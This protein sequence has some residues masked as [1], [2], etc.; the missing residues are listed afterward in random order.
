MK[1]V[2]DSGL[3]V[4]YYGP[5]LDKRGAVMKNP[6][7]TYVKGEPVVNYAGEIDIRT[8]NTDPNHPNYKLGDY[9][10]NERSLIQYRYNAAGTAFGNIPQE[11]GTPDAKKSQRESLSRSA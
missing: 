1:V 4:T 10:P 2:E 6:D 3:D 8:K 11:W 9:I 5:V 7:G